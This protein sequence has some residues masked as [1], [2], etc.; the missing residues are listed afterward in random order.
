MNRTAPK[1][2]D[3]YQTP[4]IA[5]DAFLNAMN[6][7]E[8]YSSIL[9]PC[10]G[11]KPIGKMLRKNG[12]KNITEF[13]L[14]TGVNFLEYSAKDLFDCLLMNPPYSLKEKFITKALTVSND[15]F[16]FL[17]M[18]V[19]N[20]NRFNRNF[21]QNRNYQGRWL[22]TPKM[23]LTE[24]Y[25]ELPSIPSGGYWSYAWFWFSRFERSISQSFED[26]IDIPTL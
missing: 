8:K 6:G 16:V 23:H 17:P 13:D 26:Y 9:D 4:E 12:Y 22:I 19:V 24:D 2:R 5:I 7:I 15:V 20:Y 25:H 18:Q 10:C 21:I 3:F 11:N 1:G 14:E